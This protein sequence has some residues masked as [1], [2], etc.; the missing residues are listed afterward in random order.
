MEASNLEYGMMVSDAQAV[1]GYNPAALMDMDEATRLGTMQSMRIANLQG[2]LPH[3][4]CL[5]VKA[6][7][8]VHPWNPL[9]AQHRDLVECCDENGNT[10]PA[11]WKSRVSDGDASADNAKL[12]IQARQ[13]MIISRQADKVAGDYAQGV[14][15]SRQENS[16]GL[17]P[18][19]RLGV[20]S[21]DDIEKL[22]A[23]LRDK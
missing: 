6:T 5:K 19:D 2:P 8:V 13:Q 1:G 7:G 16:D 4:P 15:Q 14:S 23:Q 12:M 18:Y 10:D 3:S 17:S 21:Y 9:L 20:V 11:A 22:R